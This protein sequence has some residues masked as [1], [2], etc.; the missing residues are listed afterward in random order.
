MGSFSLCRVE[1]NKHLKPTPRYPGFAY[2]PGI[3]YWNTCHWPLDPLVN[4]KGAS[5]GNSRATFSTMPPEPAEKN[6]PKKRGFVRESCE[7]TSSSQGLISWGFFTGYPG[8]DSWTTQEGFAWMSSALKFPRENN[9]VRAHREKELSHQKHPKLP[10]TN[11]APWLVVSTHLK[12]MLVK[13]VSFSP[14]RGENKKY[15]KPPPSTWKWAGPQKEFHLQHHTLSCASC[16]FQGGYP[17]LPMITENNPTWWCF[18]PPIWKNI[19]ASQIRPSPQGFN[20]ITTLQYIDKVLP[21]NVQLSH[22]K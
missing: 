19:C 17:S 9:L 21:R 8:G 15:L 16:Q 22:Q 3:F 4:W 6:A 12:N 10:E 2:S 20:K 14:N 11:K 13:M 18:S 5:W 1:N 7:L